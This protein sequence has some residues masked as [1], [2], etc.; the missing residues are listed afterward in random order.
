MDVHDIGI[1]CMQE[2]RH[3]ETHPPIP[4]DQAYTFFG[5]GAQREGTKLSGG[6]G[7]M[8]HASLSPNVTLLG[9][10]KHVTTN[11]QFTPIWL[12]CKGDSRGQNAYIGNI[13]FPDAS[14]F[15]TRDGKHM[16]NTA[17]E[18]WKQDIVKLS[19][20]GRVYSLGDNNSRPANSLE[21]TRNA[22]YQYAPKYGESVAKANAQGRILLE[23]CKDLNLKF[24][25]G[26][27]SPTIPTY[28]KGAGHSDIDH[29]LTHQAN[30]PAG[31]TCVT[32]PHGAPEMQ[33]CESNH[34][35][36]YAEVLPPT[37][38]RE[39]I[40]TVHTTFRRERIGQEPYTSRFKKFVAQKCSEHTEILH[41]EGKDHLM[42]DSSEINGIALNIF[43]EGAF[44]AC[45]RGKDHRVRHFQT[46]DDPPTQTKSACKSKLQQSSDERI[47]NSK[48]VKRKRNANTTSAP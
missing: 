20:K 37:T 47:Q 22:I 48:S 42:L 15:A 21:T 1:L 16:F 9:Q 23:T 17:M 4:V 45:F 10:L 32:V 3:V 19:G 7:F 43:Q 2:T 14:R 18:Q 39:V 8:V 5:V 6:M 30:H 36:V 11:N 33:E 27:T 44:D 38:T 35:M 13:Y 26:Q 46:M 25:S 12:K 29:I 28:K 41:V 31:V 24:L 34:T 40:R